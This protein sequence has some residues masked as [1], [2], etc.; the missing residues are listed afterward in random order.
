MHQEMNP[1]TV[2]HPSNLLIP[3]QFRPSG[4]PLGLK[5]DPESVAER[6]IDWLG[7]PSTDLAVVNL[8]D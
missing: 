4:S 7:V 5:V 2:I 1:D 3:S 6:V 8:V